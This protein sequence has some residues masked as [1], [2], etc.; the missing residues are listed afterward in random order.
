MAI[1]CLPP[2]AE[3]AGKTNAAWHRRQ[4]PRSRQSCFRKFGFLPLKRQI[5]AVIAPQNCYLSNHIR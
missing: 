1:C 3:K 5:A 4:C 2:I